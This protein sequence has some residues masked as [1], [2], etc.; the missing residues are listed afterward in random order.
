MTLGSAKGG[1]CGVEMTLHRPVAISA[2][3]SAVSLLYSDF[4]HHSRSSGYPRYP[5]YLGGMVRA[6]RN[7]PL[8][9]VRKR[10]DFDLNTARRLTLGRN[11][12]ARYVALPRREISSSLTDHRR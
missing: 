6:R 3:K 11:E 9:L 8:R 2:P 5:A 7:A 10:F 4:A 12:L 1:R